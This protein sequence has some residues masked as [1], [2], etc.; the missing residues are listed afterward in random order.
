MAEPVREFNANDF[1]VQRSSPQF[2]VY[3]TIRMSS[4]PGGGAHGV[5]RQPPLFAAPT[6]RR[7]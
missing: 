5:T 3:P 7:M 1:W 2:F 6:G 4:S